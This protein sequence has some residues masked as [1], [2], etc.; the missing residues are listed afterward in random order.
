ME[1]LVIPAG[2]LKLARPFAGS[3][4][5]S[6]DT[7][8]KPVQVMRL[9]FSPDVLQEVLKA[10]GS[11]GKGL[12]VSFGKAIVRHL[13][14]FPTMMTVIANNPVLLKDVPLWE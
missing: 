11:N 8:A 6:H 1:T 5:G 3:D 14:L 13:C 10:A 9:D 2:G 12:N 4:N 7:K